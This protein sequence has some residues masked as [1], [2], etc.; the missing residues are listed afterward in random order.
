MN[1]TN[2]A[3]G[4]IEVGVAKYEGSCHCGAVRFEV[5][6]DLSKGGG[7]CNCSIC[8]RVAQFGSMVKPAAFRLLAGEGNL[9]IYEWGQK[10][11]RR[12]FC[13]TCGVHCFGAGHLE[14]LGGDFVSVNLNCLEGVELGY[15]PVI[16]WDGRHDNWQAGPRPAPWPVAPFK[17]RQP[18]SMA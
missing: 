2:T 6:L 10:I 4:A 14:V 18:L 5:E 12:H 13:K 17:E 8:Q 3:N 7:R 11:S 15:L 1:K 9:G 16:Y